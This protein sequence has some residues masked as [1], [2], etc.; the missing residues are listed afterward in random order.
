MI[1]ITNRK[2]LEHQLLSL[3]D[4]YAGS[5]LVH[6]TLLHQNDL[7]ALLREVCSI[8]VS[9]GGFVAAMV[10]DLDKETRQLHI[11][12][13]ACPDPE[14][15]KILDVLELSADPDSPAG[16]GTVGESV[17]TG[18][19]V[20]INDFLAHPQ[21]GLW[22]ERARHTNVRA[23]ASFPLKK[24]GEVT[25]TLIVLSNKVGYF[26][27]EV[28]SLLTS[29][30]ESISYCIDS[31]EH[32]ENLLL[33]STVFREAIEGVIIADYRGKVLMANRSFQEITGFLP[34]DILGRDVK[35]FQTDSHDPHLFRKIFRAIASSGRWEGEVW[36]RRQNGQIRLHRLSVVGIRSGKGEISHF[37][38][39]LS[40]ITAQREEED[41]MRRLA[42]HDP[43]TGLPNRVLFHDR[44]DQALR[45]AKRSDSLM[46]I[47][48]LDLDDF[49]PVNDRYGHQAG[50]EL[51]KE[52]ARRLERLIRE[53]DTVCRIGGDEFIVLFSNISD[54]DEIEFIG[55]KL[56]Q[57]VSKPFFWE[58][59]SLTVTASAGLALYPHDAGNSTDL[60]TQS[61]WAMYQAKK[62]GRNRLFWKVASSTQNDG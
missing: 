17:R 10:A 51:L 62:Y 7:S 36:N 1:D 21:T 35:I 22:R 26:Q 30:S 43:L 12:T 48:Y 39:F 31:L 54:C 50:D 33:S 16:I 60:L 13:T 37:I 5:A 45:G 3:K 23:V 47:C 44:L 40:D 41:R 6:Q 24:K 20:F 29:M 58:G 19:P 59:V 25:G 2:K 15:K 27:S 38:G 56:L 11:Q 52:V 53:S 57:E 32:R 61:D 8:G 42:F 34:E 4:L 55:N 28:L 18:K 49:K 46:G 14:I 9:F